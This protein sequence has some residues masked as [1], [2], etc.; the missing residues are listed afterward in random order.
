MIMLRRRML[1]RKTDPKTGKH[2]L[3][4]HA[5]ATRAWTFHKSHFVWK[6]T[7]RMAGTPPGTSFCGSLRGRNAHGQSTRAILY[8]ILQGKCRTPQI[9]TTS[10]EH[11]ALS[12]TV[13]TPVAC[14]HS[15]W[16]KRFPA[17]SSFKL[18][19]EPSFQ[20]RSTPVSKICLWHNPIVG[21][22]AGHIP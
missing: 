2:T 9:I 10:I 6:F 13:R 3:C 17:V 19:F 1:R 7:G 16:G 11:R 5:L 18:P 22:S 20:T 12:V 15:V 4:E 21:W 8:G 14:G